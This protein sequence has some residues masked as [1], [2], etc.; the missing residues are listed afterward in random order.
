MVF[1]PAY[2]WEEFSLPFEVLLDGLKIKL[3]SAR[4]VIKP[5]QETKTIKD[6]W[7]Y[8]SA[9]TKQKRVGVWD[10]EANYANMIEQIYGKQMIEG[11]RGI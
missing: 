4:Y 5:W 8:I 1:R 9:W 11:H 7:V 10:L 3:D 6:N 2:C